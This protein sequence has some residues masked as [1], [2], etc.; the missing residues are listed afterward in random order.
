MRSMSL[1]GEQKD[2]PRQDGFPDQYADIHPVAG[3]IPGLI[4]NTEEQILQ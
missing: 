2:I 4:R 1:Q 3:H